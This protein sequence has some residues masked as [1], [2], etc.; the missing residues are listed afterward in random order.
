MISRIDRRVALGTLAA[1][2]VVLLVWYFALWKPRQNEIAS[3]KAQLATATQ[4]YEQ[5]KAEYQAILAGNEGSAVAQAQTQ[6]GLLAQA[7]PSNV[8]LAGILN[9]VYT[10]GALSG[11]PI[12][13]ITPAVPGSTTGGSSSSSQQEHLAIS[14]TGRYF[15]I[16]DFIDQI[17]QLPRIYVISSVSLAGVSNGTGGV[18]SNSPNTL[19]TPDLTVSIAATTYY[20]AVP[21]VVPSVTTTTV[22]PSATSTTAPPVS[23]PTSPTSPTTSLTVPASTGSGSPSTTRAV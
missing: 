3:K 15:Q 10:A 5:Y 7:I 9:D 21:S 17:Q 18:Q 23:A 16:V 12:S 8:D 14:T 4:Q 22:V 2:V 11:V 20:S 1:L 13:S 19:F 6:A